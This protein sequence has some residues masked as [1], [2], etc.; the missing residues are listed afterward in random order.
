[1]TIHEFLVSEP[2]TP[3]G[4]V[5]QFDLLG[6]AE[7]FL[8]KWQPRLRLAD[9]DIWVEIGKVDDDH[10]AES[11]IEWRTRRAHLTFP[12]DHIQRSRDRGETP[13]GMND[14]EIVEHTVIHELLHI[15][16]QPLAARVADEIDWMAG[17]QG[18]IGA[19]LRG[20][21]REYR[22]WWINAMVRT[23]LEAERS[24]GWQ[25]PIHPLTGAQQ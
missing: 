19:E 8:K 2:P 15:G 5:V 23:L 17:K 4:H 7:R 3:N 11:S 14:A 22:E 18:A 6:K 25:Q 12:A 24:S 9:W 16:E 21:W 13:P 1:M 10:A 20:G